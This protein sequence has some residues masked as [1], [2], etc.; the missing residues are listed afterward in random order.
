MWFLVSGNGRCEPGS[1][2]ARCASLSKQVMEEVVAEF[3]TIVSRFH[4]DCKR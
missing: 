3:V 2:A 4:N 1:S